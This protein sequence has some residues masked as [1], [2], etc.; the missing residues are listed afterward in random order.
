M[1]REM[2]I[3]GMSVS[4]SDGERREAFRNGMHFFCPKPTETSLLETV[5]NIRRQSA[6]VEETLEMIYT[7]LK[8]ADGKID[9]SIVGT[10]WQSRWQS[11]RNSFT[12]I[13]GGG[14]R[15]STEA[16]RVGKLA[17]SPS[18]QELLN[19]VPD[20]SG[21]TGKGNKLAAWKIFPAPSDLES[22]EEAHKE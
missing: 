21:K 16:A 8:Y 18:L 13:Q 19:L 22:L 10:R 12:L 2:L 20:V 14:R 5:L 9:E 3:L 17:V 11:R 7:V 15:G 1:N 4:A 6:D